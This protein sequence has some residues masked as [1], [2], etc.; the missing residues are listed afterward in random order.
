MSWKNVQYENGK[1]RTN[2]GGGGS[3]HTYS[4]TEQVIGTWIDGKPLYEKT[5]Q[6]TMPIVTQEG[7]Y[8][9]KA[10]S[11]AELNV[12]TVVDITARLDQNPHWCVLPYISN[13]N[14]MSKAYYNED[15][16]IF[17]WSS[18]TVHSGKDVYITLQYTKTTD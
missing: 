5:L 1:F 17:L 11:C 6:N 4:T 14:N 15:Y 16:G 7:T 3:G 9:S 8:A 13:S 2:E 12:E 10:V 18:M